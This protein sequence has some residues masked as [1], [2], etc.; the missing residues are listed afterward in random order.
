MRRS[1]ALNLSAVLTVTGHLAMAGILW[2]QVP[3]GDEFR[4][5]TYTTG[6]QRFRSIAA[7]ANSFVVAWESAGQDG[8]QYGVFVQRYTA[9]PIAPVGPEFQV[10]SYTTSDQLLP[11]VAFDQDADPF[12]VVWQSNGQDGD[13]PGVFGQRYAAWGPAYGGEFRV[14]SYTTLAQGL[15]VVAGIPSGFVVVWQSMG[16]DGSDYGIFGQRY[17]GFGAPLGGEFRVNTYTAGPQ[18]TPRV[19]SGSNGDFIV[20][21]EGYSADDQL[22]GIRGQR[23]SSAGLPLGGEFR[24]NSY[25]TGNQ[26]SP[27]VDVFFTS[28]VVVWQSDGQD[29]SGAGVFGQVYNAAGVPQGPEFRVN[30]H[31]TSDQSL[32]DVSFAAGGS[33]LVLWQSDLQDG[34]ATGIYAAKFGSE[35]RVNTYTA[36]PQTGPGIAFAGWP[37][38]LS[39]WTSAQDPDGSLGIYA[40]PWT[41]LPVELQTFVVE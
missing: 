25:T 41:D 7:G 30:T 4:I 35:F 27:A 21:W 31:T 9:F 5:N 23:Y 3:W 34:S 28:P 18:R 36:G 17:D 20:V 11:Q 39:P 16:Q 26:R 32:P 14:N 13:G 38:W 40:Q 22:L 19:A 2:A 15:P 33:F 37:S 8:S 12:V 6:T 24:V 1:T 29:G 10:N